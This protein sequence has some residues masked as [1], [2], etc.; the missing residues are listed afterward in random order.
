MQKFTLFYIDIV[1][2]RFYHV[3]DVFFNFFHVY[4]GFKNILYF[5]LES[6]FTSTP[7]FNHCV[8]DKYSAL[9]QWNLSAQRNA[10]I[11]YAILYVGL[12]DAL[13][14]WTFHWNVVQNCGLWVICH[15]TSLRYSVEY[16]VILVTLAPLISEWVNLPHISHSNSKK[17]YQLRLPRVSQVL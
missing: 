5:F 10:N 3:L 1:D 9:S 7:A 8:E 6:F 13:I 14:D 15:G 4:K 17:N 2:K 12:S 11:V 16:Y